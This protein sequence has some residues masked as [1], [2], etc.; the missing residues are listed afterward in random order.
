MSIHDQ[1]YIIYTAHYQET[2]ALVKLLTQKNGVVSAVVRGVHQSNK[3][4]NGLRATVQLG[5]LVEC[6]WSGKTSL[7]TIY[8]MELLQAA[9]FDSTEKFICLS[10]IH[11]LLLF[12][13]R[14]E[15]HIDQI[16]DQY[17]GFLVEMANNKLEPALR[18]FEFQLL[19]IMGYGIDFSREADVD[20][21]VEPNKKYQ[22]IP[23]FGV[24]CAADLDGHVYLGTDLLAIHEK[25]FAT[26]V[27]LAVAKKISRTLLDYHMEGRPIKARQL[28]RE[29]FC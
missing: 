16:F 21:P 11:E 9:S 6:Q 4:S 13:L 23:G 26:P 22:V 24:R 8:Q 17:G 2:S 28:Y 25:K 5:N 18:E 12:F 15:F 29:L 20:A 10:Y 19:E 1:A 14:E 3:K 27:S 7:K